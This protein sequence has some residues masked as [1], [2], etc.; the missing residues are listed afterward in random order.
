MITNKRPFKKK[1]KKITNK[2]QFSNI[3]G[4]KINFSKSMINKSILWKSNELII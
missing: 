4:H 1:K 2:R 3:M